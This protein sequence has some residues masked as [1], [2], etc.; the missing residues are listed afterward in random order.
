VLLDEELQP[1]TE[2]KIHVFL[3]GI[4]QHLNCTIK[5][6]EEAIKIEESRIKNVIFVPNKNKKKCLLLISTERTKSGF[7]YSNHLMIDLE[8]SN[9]NLEL[10][11]NDYI[12]S[13]VNFSKTPQWLHSGGVFYEVSFV[14]NEPGK[15]EIVFKELS[16]E[17]TDERNIIDYF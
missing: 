9:V 1:T 4:W 16:V 14:R 3:E 5:N 13:H 8:N 6:G 2:L 7:I 12:Y 15:P 17:N 10:L 11:I